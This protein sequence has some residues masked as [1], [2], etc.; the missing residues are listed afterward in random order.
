[1]LATDGNF[2]GT[3]SSGGNSE[4]AGTI[5]KITRGGTLTTLYSFC[6]T[7]LCSDGK[8]PLALMQASNGNFYGVTSNFGLYN[9]GTIFE[10]SRSGVF[11]VL[12]SFCPQSN[13]SDG[14]SQPRS[15]LMQASNGNLYGTTFTGGANGNGTVYEISPAGLF[16]T[17]H[18]FCT[19]SLCADGASPSAGLVEDAH[20]N[21]Y[22]TTYYGGA[23][24][25]GSVF[26]ITAAGQFI[27]L[28]SF[29]NTAGSYPS[30]AL[31][32]ASDGNL[33]GATYESSTF[34]GTIFQIT[35]AHVFGSLYSFCTQSG[36]AGANPL[37]TLFQ[38]TAGAFYGTTSYG[39]PS[40]DG[41]IFTFS[42][43]LPPLVET[44]PTAAKVGAHVRRDPV[45]HFE[46][47][48]RDDSDLVAVV[49]ADVQRGT[50]QT[51][52]HLPPVRQGGDTAGIGAKSLRFKPRCFR[53]RKSDAP[54]VLS[55]CWRCCLSRRR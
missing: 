49:L 27:V 17:I 53:S 34:A 55:I 40:N 45:A 51:A 21:F 47:D 32:L 15:G 6:P 39:G 43:G 54:N 44:I 41:T 12:Y 36:C 9:N 33:Y 16:R 3:T 37:G 2:Y 26:E 30:S 35:A 13:C 7:K 42:M 50:E 20:G 28:H 10:F 29:D 25:F 8:Y 1:M 5:Y 48:L 11:T 46:V 24:S 14:G 38:A 19:Q 31:I 18:D 22:G 4:Q 23:N 52:G